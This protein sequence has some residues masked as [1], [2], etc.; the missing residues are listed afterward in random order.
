MK[1]RSLVA[2]ALF[3]GL[4][5]LLGTLGCTQVEVVGAEPEGLLVVGTGK[6]TVQPDIAIVSVGVQT[7]HADAQQAVAENNAKVSAILDALRALGIAPGDLRTERFS[8]TPQMQYPREG[9]PQLVGFQVTNS[10]RATVRDVT[11]VGQV[12]QAAVDAGANLI[13][14]IVFDVSNRE[15][16]VA[17]ARRLAIADARTQAEE[18]AEEADISLGEPIRIRETGG[19]GPI[20]V[21]GLER[22]ADAAVPVEPGT[23]DITVTVEILYEIE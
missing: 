16:L 13:H 21:F 6:V 5:L 4:G 23:V 20:P 9:P 17:E 19:G 3:L 12:L 7:F 18:I 22:A 10:V 8:V 1:R 15:E 2:S 14:G 11:Q